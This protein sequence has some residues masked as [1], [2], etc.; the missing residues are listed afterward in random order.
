MKHNHVAILIISL[1]LQIIGI[2]WY[3]G[4][5]FGP[6]WQEQLGGPTV[7]A[8]SANPLPYIISL[9]STIIICYGASW[10]ISFLEIKSPLKAI[11]TSI[12]ISFFFLLPVI[13]SHYAFIKV[14]YMVALIDWAM[15][16][17]LVT[18]AFVLLSF[19][20]VKE[21]DS[22]TETKEMRNPIPTTDETKNI[23]KQ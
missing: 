12:F 6:F 9:I 16:M 8:T 13:S 14:N 1:F 11:T 23:L 20:R 21:N 17:I 18:L 10:I 7:S 3:S 5:G 2:I 15:S 19:F 22:L 4:W